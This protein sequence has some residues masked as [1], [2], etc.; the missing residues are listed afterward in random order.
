MQIT[1]KRFVRI[2]LVLVEKTKQ[3]AVTWEC[4]RISKIF[5]ATVYRHCALLLAERE[6]TK[7]WKGD[8]N[9][10]TVLKR[11]GL[12][13]SINAAGAPSQFQLTSE[14]RIRWTGSTTITNRY[15]DESSC[16]LGT[17]LTVLRR[18]TNINLTRLNNHV[19]LCA[20]AAACF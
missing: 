2:E 20:R 14:I 4:N 8:R 10:R 1:Y 18:N 6:G 19:S 5:T 3:V 17:S 11:H 15:E 13:W 16:A 7:K 9:T 12:R